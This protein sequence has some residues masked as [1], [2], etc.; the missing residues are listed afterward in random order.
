MD[1][2][3]VPLQSADRDRHARRSY[4]WDLGFNGFYLLHSRY[5]SV[6]APILK[7]GVTGPTVSWIFNLDSGRPSAWRRSL[8]TNH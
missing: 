3:E 5:N 2:V 8:I 4:G 1:S 7:V 6:L